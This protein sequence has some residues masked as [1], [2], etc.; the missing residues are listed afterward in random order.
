MRGSFFFFWGG[1]II[2]VWILGGFFLFVWYRP[3]RYFLALE[4]WI[5]AI[6]IVFRTLIWESED[7][8]VRNWAILGSDILTLQY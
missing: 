3:L 2:I 7:P 8:M 4:L 5:W 1:G 6:Y